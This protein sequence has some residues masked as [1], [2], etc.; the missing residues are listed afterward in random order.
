MNV[1]QE[2]AKAKAL[3]ALD[4]ARAAYMA[5]FRECSFAIEVFDPPSE[6]ALGALDASLH[7]TSQLLARIEEDFATIARA[8]RTASRKGA[9]ARAIRTA[10]RT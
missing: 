10:S 5:A 9:Y 2:I 7:T 4:V 8:I 6:R 3:A 1:N